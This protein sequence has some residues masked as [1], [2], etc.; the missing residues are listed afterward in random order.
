MPGFDGTGPA[1]RGPFT[2]RGRGY[3]VAR[4]PETAEEPVRG[5][6]GRG[7]VPFTAPAGGKR[8]TEL[9]R[10]RLQTRSLQRELAAF[11]SL[12]LMAKQ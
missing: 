5:V 11:R 10:L 3:C 4:M 2:G 12:L 8:R 6:A 7:G 1:G 9:H